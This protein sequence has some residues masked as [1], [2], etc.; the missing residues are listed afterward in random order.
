MRKPKSVIRG[1]VEPKYYFVHTCGYEHSSQTH[2]IK[3]TRVVALTRSQPAPNIRNPAPLRTHWCP[4]VASS[5]CL[6]LGQCPQKLERARLSASIFLA[7][8]IIHHLRHTAI[9]QN[10][11]AAAHCYCVKHICCDIIFTDK[12]DYKKMFIFPTRVF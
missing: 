2:M 6:A 11:S 12:C 1:S 8:L 5:S 7:V 9:V 3:T 10:I 4:C